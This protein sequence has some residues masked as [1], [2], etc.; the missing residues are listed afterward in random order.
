MV[1]QAFLPGNLGSLCFLWEVCSQETHNV[2]KQIGYPLYLLKGLLPPFLGLGYEPP[3]HPEHNTL[4]S[5]IVL[6][7]L[8][9][10]AQW[11]ARRRL[12]PHP[13]NL[14]CL[15]FGTLG[16]SGRRLVRISFAPVSLLPSLFWESADLARDAGRRS[17]WLDRRSTD[18][19]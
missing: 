3:P 15:N 1:M 6:S 17:P 19:A 9:T 2:T 8:L 10:F 13:S 16:L 4:P 14:W 18:A 5:P 11:P 12:S 7:H